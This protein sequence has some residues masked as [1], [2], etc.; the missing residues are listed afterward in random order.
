M[1]T[2]AAC[3]VTGEEEGL[4]FVAG[5]SDALT[6]LLVNQILTTCLARPGKNNL[7]LLECVGVIGDDGRILLVG[8]DNGGSLLTAGDNL[9]LG[10]LGRVSGALGATGMLAVGT[11]LG[12]SKGSIASVAGSSNAHADR[13]VHAKNGVVGRSR[14]QLGK[15]DVEAVTLTQLLGTLLKQLVA[16][17]LGNALHALVLGASLIG[18]GDLGHGSRFAVSGL[19][20]GFLK[21]GFKCLSRQDHNRKATIV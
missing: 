3:L 7:L 14:L 21:F 12:R 4:A 16:G 6:G 20:W 1:S 2:F 15:L 19:A 18:L 8:L 11:F 17:K 5:S 13:L 10:A 9:G